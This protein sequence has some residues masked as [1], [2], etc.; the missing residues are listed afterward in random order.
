VRH[1]GT[2]A[3]R[4]LAKDRGERPRPRDAAE[5]NGGRADGIPKHRDATASASARCM[6][7]WKRGGAR[8]GPQKPVSSANSRRNPLYPQIRAD[9]RRSVAGM[10]GTYSWR[11]DSAGA[12]YTSRIDRTDRKREEWPRESTNGTSCEPCSRRRQG[13]DSEQQAQ[14]YL[15]HAESQSPQRRLTTKDTKGTKKP[16]TDGPKPYPPAGGPRAPR[17]AAQYRLR[18]PYGRVGAYECTAI[19]LAVR[20]SSPQARRRCMRG[21][22]GAGPEQARKSR[23]AER[24][25]GAILSAHT[26]T[27]N[28]RD[29]KDRKEKMAARKRKRRKL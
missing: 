18:P 10:S 5:D 7:P 24:T 8:T 4:H 20:L 17:N 26:K 16:G 25:A 19:A 9:L 11:Q 12:S 27:L 21:G 29:R 1:D 13:S 2:Q 3:R 23:G 6:S 15:S 22:S 28:R 14:T